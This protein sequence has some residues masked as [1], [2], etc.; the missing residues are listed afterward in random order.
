MERNISKKQCVA[1]LV[2][3]FIALYFMIR[4]RLDLGVVLLLYKIT[5]CRHG[6]AKSIRYENME[7]KPPPISDVF[8]SVL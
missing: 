7:D 5:K 6:A 4:E 2:A 1:V 3:C 8:I